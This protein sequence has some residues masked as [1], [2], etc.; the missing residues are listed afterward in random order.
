MGQNARHEVIMA[1]VGGKGVL[2]SGD[3]LAE[4]AMP[5]Y[6]NIV[7]FP[8]YAS[9][10]RGGS[11]ECTVVLSDESIA[12]PILPVADTIVVLAPSELKTFEKRVKP[13]GTLII[14]STG[15]LPQKV[16]RK[17]IKVIEIPG[18]EKAVAVGDIRSA[19]LVLLG[20]YIGATGAV[21]PELIEKELEKR[22]GKSKKGLEINKKAFREGIKSVQTAKAGG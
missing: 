20:A 10:M 9:A 14:E 11:C 13:G 7:W 18:V 12:S 3:I 17:D 1:G 15:G 21:S 6:R 16:E 4:S 8:S 22:F 19:N 2:L 5:Q